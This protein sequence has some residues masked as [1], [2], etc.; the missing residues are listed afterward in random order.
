MHFLV[1]DDDRALYRETLRRAL[2]PRGAFV[3]GTFAEDG[4]T[5]C[6]DLPVRRYAPD[7][8]IDLLGE[9]E[10]IE[11]RRQVHTTPATAAQPFNWIAGRIR[12]DNW[13]PP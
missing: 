4:P 8:L 7:D 9:I 13:E 2:A 11:Q 6:S 12:S 3:I 1:N 10:I 5:Q